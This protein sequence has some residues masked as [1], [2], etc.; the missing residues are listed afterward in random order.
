M[1]GVTLLGAALFRAVPFGVAR[2]AT[3]YGVVLFGAGRRGV[4][5]CAVV[6]AGSHGRGPA[7][8]NIRAHNRGKYG[9]V[10]PVVA[11]SSTSTPGTT[12]PTTA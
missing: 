3:R 8:S 4:T 5:P 1:L 11:M 2:R 9:T 12:S 6:A 10:L 7:P